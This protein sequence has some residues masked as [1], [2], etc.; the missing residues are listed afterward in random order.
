MMKKLVAALVLALLAPTAVAAQPNYVQ[1]S[2]WEIFRNDSTAPGCCP[3]QVPTA[4][5]WYPEAWRIAPGQGAT[6]EAWPYPNNFGNGV[7]GNVLYI[8]WNRWQWVPCLSLPQS[9]CPPSS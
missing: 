3:V 7:Q 5:L 4:G 8:H 2:R 6:I 1:N 9:S